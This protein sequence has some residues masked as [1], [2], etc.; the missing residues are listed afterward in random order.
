ML[1]HI[2]FGG[3][4][5]LYARSQA[6]HRG[7]CLLC[8]PV[9]DDGGS[10]RPELREIVTAWLQLPRRRQ[11]SGFDCRI[12]IQIQPLRGLEWSA[13]T[14]DNVIVT[15]VREPMGM[16]DVFEQGAPG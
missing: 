15:L 1:F 4:G 5:T 3:T 10:V 9:G 13:E 8:H 14:G 2:Q 11:V 6:F 12:S 16:L 7:K